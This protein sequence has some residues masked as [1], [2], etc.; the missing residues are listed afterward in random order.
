VPGL[1]SHAL[2]LCLLLAACPAYAFKVEIKGANVSAYLR[3][4]DGRIQ[5][6]PYTTSTRAQDPDSQ[7]VFK[8]KDLPIRVAQRTRASAT[9]TP[10]QI[11]NGVPV[12]LV[13]DA[14]D[15]RSHYDDFLFCRPGEVYVG[16]FSRRPGNGGTDS[17][18]LEVEP[19]TGT[20]SDG[21]GNHIPFTEIS[22]TTRGNASGGG[23]EASQPI[24]SG[25]FSAGRQTVA[26]FQVNWWHESCHQFY[27]LNSQVVAAGEYNGTVTYTLSVP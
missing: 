3:V 19:D 27:Y 6:A 24:L 4:G 25:R 11:G 17:V 20:L 22:W 15:L 10:S 7:W 2:A 5:G 18:S 1:R 9:L 14:T 23:N 21:N 16:G 26:S 12:P 13:S 8:D